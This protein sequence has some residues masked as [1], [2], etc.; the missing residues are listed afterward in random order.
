MPVLLLFIVFVV[1]PIVELLLI[2]Q[3]A[4]LLGGGAL[5][6][7]LTIGL[8]IADSLLGAWLLR[9][10]GRGVWRQFTAELD[11][12]RMPAR[13]IV[14]GAFVIVGAALLLTPGFLTDIVGVAMLL[15]PT[16]RLFGGWVF[17]L[18][19]RRVRLA[20][21]IVDPGLQNFPRS[22]QPRR[23][24]FDAEDVTERSPDSVAEAPEP[25]PGDE[26]DFDF[27][28]RRFNG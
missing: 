20:F 17:G 12:G 22:R 21:R 18:L 6:G 7:G 19:T 28:K 27:K 10:Q 8:L 16:R 4:D 3:V 11:A 15:P 13:E 24:D 14:D 2:L 9:S 25:P 5:G 1:V 23:W 26:P